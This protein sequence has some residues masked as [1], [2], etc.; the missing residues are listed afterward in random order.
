MGIEL[1]DALLLINKIK[2]SS[3]ICLWVYVYSVDVSDEMGRV[4]KVLGA[5]S[6]GE[7]P[8][9]IREVC[10]IPRMIPASTY[11]YTPELLC[12]APAESGGEIAVGVSGRDSCRP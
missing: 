7:G 12:G 3:L 5:L 11:L 10:L 6:V 2:A 4:H 8:A 9:N 1:P